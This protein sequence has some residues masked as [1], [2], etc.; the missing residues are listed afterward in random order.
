MEET[1]SEVVAANTNNPEKRLPVSKSKPSNS[2]STAENP[3][4]DISVE[5]D[6]QEKENKEVK[7]IVCQEMELET[8][9]KKVEK[10]QPGVHQKNE[11]ASK[12][13][14]NSNLDEEEVLKQVY[15]SR[16]A[17][18]MAKEIKKKIR[19]KLKEQL[20]YFSSD[21]SLHDDKLSIEKRKKKKKKVPILS[22]AETRYFPLINV[23]CSLKK[24]FY[25]FYLF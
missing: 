9:G 10:A 2:Q 17:E 1:K 7:K 16:V 3:D 5:K 6:I 24:T 15:H 20:T 4:G 19:K 14:E 8:P 12:E 11:M 23:K 25:D 18:E 22:N 13:K 21:T